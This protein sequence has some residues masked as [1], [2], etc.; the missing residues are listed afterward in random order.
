MSCV[1]CGGATTPTRYQAELGGGVLVV[2]SQCRHIAVSALPSPEELTRYYASKYSEARAAYVDKAYLA[3]MAK[4][5]VAQC[6]F[7][8]RAGVTL[9]GARVVDI[10]CGYG[11]LVA[12]L[13]KRGATAV[14]YDYDPA[15]V[16][17]CK[18]QGLEVHRMHDEAELAELGKLD[19]IT[20]SHTLEHM[21]ALEHS[22]D[23][24]RAHGQHIFIEV[25]R[26]DLELA[27]QFRDQEGHLQ[28]FNPTSLERLVRTRF[29]VTALTA[30]GPD[31]RVYWRD[32]LSVLR[33]VWRALARDWFFNAYATERETGMW[34]RAVAT[35]R[36]A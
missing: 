25:P 1:C 11:A 5:A 16:E 36:A 34:I 19:L 22:L 9:A 2:C 21:R 15:C 27:E 26:Y 14:G 10:G 35:V 13:A 4:R 24:L 32:R 31:V 7:I 20:L 8:E 28:F 33:R 23:A 29:S 30:C 3:V 12:E 17:Y 18:Q 6:D